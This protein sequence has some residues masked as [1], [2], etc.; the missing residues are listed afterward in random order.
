MPQSNAQK[1]ATAARSAPEEEGIVICHH[2]VLYW[3][4]EA[5][6]IDQ[7]KVDQIKLNTPPTQWDQILARS[8]DAQ[9]QNYPGGLASLTR[10]AIIG[11]ID[12]GLLQHS[13]VFVGAENGKAYVAGV[14]NLN[15]L[16]LSTA[17]RVGPLYALVTDNQLK[18]LE[19]GK[20]VH[21]VD[22][23]TVLARLP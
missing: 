15:V 14:N 20:Q 3:M 8:T 17:N 10:G 23:D 7:N 6:L 11:F 12:H 4:K 2:A 22:V 16:N 21:W 19:Q 13:M 18:P 9:V 5:G 1:L